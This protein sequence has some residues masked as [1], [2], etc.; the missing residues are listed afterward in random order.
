MILPPIRKTWPPS[1]LNAKPFCP[2]RIMRSGLPVT[3]V[4]V[5]A[6]IWVKVVKSK[7]VMVSVEP[8]PV[9]KKAFFK[10]ESGTIRPGNGNA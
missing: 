1:V 9:R 7:D 8:E 3:F 10:P 5:M 2:Q 4:M 6:S